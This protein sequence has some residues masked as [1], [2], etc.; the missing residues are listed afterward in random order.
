MKRRKWIRRLAYI[1]IALVVLAAVIAPAVPWIARWQLV[2]ILERQINGPVKVDGVSF[3]PKHVEVHGLQL[4]DGATP[5]RCWLSIDKA[6]LD[7]TFWKALLGRETPKLVTVDGMVGRFHLDKSIH[8]TTDFTPWA[9]GFEFPFDQVDIRNARVEICLDDQP[10]FGLDRIDMTIRGPTEAL[11]VD[12]HIVGSLGGTWD[13]SAKVN[14]KTLETE[15]NVASDSLPVVTDSLA[16]LPYVPAELLEQVRVTGDTSV[17]VAIQNTADAGLRYRFAVTSDSLSIT[18][19]L[20]DLQVTEGHCDLVVED[21]VLTLRD[22]HGQIMGGRVALNGGL[23]LFGPARQGK[24]EGELSDL[25]LSELPE[26]LNVPADVAGVVSGNVTLEGN[27]TGSKAVLQGH[28]RTA[29]NQGKVFGGAV[30]LLEADV[31]IRELAFDDWTKPPR[32][33]GTATMRS[34]MDQLELSRLFAVLP[35]ELKQ[36]IPQVSGSLGLKIG[37]T[38]PLATLTDLASYEMAGHIRVPEVTSEQ[39]TLRDVSVPLEYEDGTLSVASARAAFGENG[40]LEGTVIVP[41]FAEGDITA[42]LRCEGIESREFERWIPDIIK[43]LEATLAGTLQARVPVAQWDDS[44]AWHADGSAGIPRVRV[45]EYEVSDVAG[46]MA[47]R[48]GE[49]QVNDCQAHWKDAVIR[50][51][52]RATLQAPFPYQGNFG[53][54]DVDLSQVVETL[55]VDVPVSV[56]GKASVT[57]NLQ[58]R[59]DPLDWRI[60]GNGRLTESAVGPVELDSPSVDWKITPTQIEVSKARVGLFS[61]EIE[62]SA[63]LPLDGQTPG[64]ASGTFRDLHPAPV[65]ALMPSQPI[66]ASG[67]ASGE[68]ELTGFE[69]PATMNGAIQFRGLQAEAK[70]ASIQQLSGS[71]KVVRGQVDA[72][73]EGKTFG[74]RLSLRGGA[75]FADKP[76]SIAGRLSLDGLD[77]SML[78][79]VVNQ[80]ALNPLRA[81]VDAQMDLSAKAPTFEPQ[82]QGHVVVRDV[83]WEGTRLTNE[84]RSRATLAGTSLTIQGISMGLAGGTVTGEAAMRLDQLGI[85]SFHVDMQRVRTE[86]VLAPYDRLADLAKVRLDS[87]FHGRFAPGRVSATG[88]VRVSQGQ[89]AGIPIREVSGPVRWTIDPSR[90]SGEASMRLRQG[91]LAGGQVSGDAKVEFGRSLSIDGRTTFASIDLDPIAQAIPAL[92]KGLTGRVSGRATVQGRDI[93]DMRSLR[94]VSGSY[95]LVLSDSPVLQLPILNA[96]ADKHGIAS[97]SQHFSKTEVEGRITRGTIDIDR[98]TMAAAGIHMF[99]DGTIGKRGQLDLD[100]SADTGQ[101]MAAGMVVGLVRPID[102]TRRRLIFLNMGGTVKRPI[103]MLDMERQIQQEVLLFFFPFVIQD[104]PLS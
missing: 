101:L 79:R 18:L 43:P 51:A 104:V 74:G 69:H 3:Q 11:R 90:L 22:F 26:E 95:D 36:E 13:L 8:L 89:V 94:E 77:A 15:F 97:A 80:P 2:A 59:L 38:I 7:T 48:Q 73:L 35:P 17:R 67:T 85:G 62:M 71:V 25:S 27:T 82:G 91:D 57:G 45:A 52:G 37:G 5:P 66:Q 12:G 75:N 10:P 28:A 93:R 32:I 72:E 64:R 14:T 53:V 30:E 42:D 49:L 102:L 6:T 100:V 84:V 41:A 4:F 19:P 23:D 24:I 56:K 20:E 21:G 96:L 1:C 86:R 34:E 87:A 63:H 99:I 92:S 47:L 98:M 9:G 16:D 88:H 55:K 68:F 40:V 50:A 54:S 60:E 103:V 46:K 78:A 31:E 29:L 76:F 83:A 65:I 33:D 44:A 81:I 70:G 61:G 58:G 39:L